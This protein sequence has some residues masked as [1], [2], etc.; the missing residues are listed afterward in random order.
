MRL[1]LCT[2][3]QKKKIF[4]VEFYVDLKIKIEIGTQEN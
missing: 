1:R 2:L 3:K 4:E